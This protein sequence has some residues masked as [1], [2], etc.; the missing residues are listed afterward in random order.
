MPMQGEQERII[1]SFCFQNTTS[2]A[3]HMQQNVFKHMQL[4]RNNKKKPWNLFQI[5]EQ[6]QQHQQQEQ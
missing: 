6:E 3:I 4:K 2:L 1:T 5:T